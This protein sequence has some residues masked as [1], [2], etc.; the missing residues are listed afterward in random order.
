MTT[1]PS[2]W[3]GL[4]FSVLIVL[5]GCSGLLG[6]LQSDIGQE[7]GYSATDSV[8]VTTSD[9]LNASEREAVVHRTMARVEVIRGQEFTKDVPVRVISREQYRNESGTFAVRDDPNYTAWNNQVWEAR[10][11]VDEPTNANKAVEGVYA[12][13]VLGYYSNGEI[14][15]VSDSKTPRIDSLTLAHELTH[16]LQDQQLSLGEGNFDQTQDAQLAENGL[17][18]GDANSVESRY[19]ERCKND[20]SCLP[21]PERPEQSNRADFNQGVYTTVIMPYIAGPDFVDALHERGGWSAVNGAYEDI[22]QSSEQIIHPER[23]PNDAPVN[24]TVEDR[25]SNE[26]E[27]LDVN[28]QAETAGE[29]SIYTMFWMNGVIDK[30]SH[31]QYNYSHPLSA[32]WAGDSLVPYQNTAGEQNGYVWKTEWDSPEDASQFSDGYKRLLKQKGAKQTGNTY[33][34][35]EK[36]PYGDAFR[37][38]RQGTT[39]TIVNAPTVEELD[40]V[41]RSSN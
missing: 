16:A 26:W 13:A 24:V 30:Q 19:E 9:G 17:I 11:L 7:D 20:W 39:V 33:V 36:N 10:F 6:G 38:S 23:Y 4:A 21:Q 35:P 1:R 14:V 37:V 3:T 31:Y 34:I 27:R 15:I 28:P 8:N 41:H 12:G 18:E 40:R 29:A 5:S 22:P 25:S 32:G 2:E